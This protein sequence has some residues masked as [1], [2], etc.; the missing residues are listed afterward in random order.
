[1]NGIGGDIRGGKRQNLGEIPRAVLQKV[2]NSEEKDNFENKVFASLESLEEKFEQPNHMSKR[3]KK[4]ALRNGLITKFAVL[5][6]ILVSLVGIFVSH[7]YDLLAIFVPS[8]QVLASNNTDTQ[9]AVSDTTSVLPEKTEPK[10]EIFLN[11]NHLSIP[12]LSIEAPI[13]WLIAN[14]SSATSAALEN[15]LIQL[16]KTALPGE[17]GNIYITGHSS[18]YP[19]AKGSYNS[20]FAKLGNLAIGEK[21]FIQ[22]KSQLFTYKVS[23]KKVVSAKDVSMM[24]QNKTDHK[25][26]LVTCWPVGTNLKRL[27]VVA[28]LISPSDDTP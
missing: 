18:N 16:E 28:E 21:I 1:M 6:L 22:Y 4:K 20:V 5:W 14:N 9:V 8:N 12:S 11:E 7:N 24:E 19:W 3:E 27:M 10:A 2:K 13:N 15:G 23:E 26:T 25:L 17:A